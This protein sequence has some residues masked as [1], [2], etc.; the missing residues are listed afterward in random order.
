MKNNSDPGSVPP[1]I[2]PPSES[3]ERARRMMSMVT[4][5][6]GLGALTIAMLAGGKLLLEILSEGLSSNLNTVG[7]KLLWVAIPFAVGWMASLIS[8]RGT[9]N[10]VLPLI[11]RYYI[12]L[13]VL[14]IALLY[15]RVI[16]KLF[17]E[18]FSSSH[19][20]RYSIVFVAAFSALIGLH[21]LIEDH[22]LR[23]FSVPLLAMSLIHLVVAVSHYVFLDGDPVFA[24]GDL[25]YFLS[26]LTIVM[27]MALH[28]GI[29][30]PF[31][32]SIDQIF[33]DNEEIIQ[34]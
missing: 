25:F 1:F 34:P 5:I 8:I 23:P 22:D 12:G 6:V 15:A 28:L 9:N 31:R 14:G 30:N 7:A 13:T 4:M 17:L 29:L 27:L 10:L 3:Q 2:E 19:Y 33:R 26:M 18:S 32:N 16:Q 11:I 21:L 20:L 24:M